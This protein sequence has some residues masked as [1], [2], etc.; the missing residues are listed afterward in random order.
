[1]GDT[2]LQPIAVAIT[3]FCPCLAFVFVVLRTYSRYFLTETLDWDDTLIGIPMVLSIGLAYVTTEVELRDPAHVQPDLALV[4]NAALFLFLRVGG[5]KPTLRKF[6]WALL[7]INNAMMVAIFVADMLQCIP[8]RKTFYPTIPGQC[9]SIGD[10]FIATAALTILTDIL[11]L[12]IPVWLVAGLQ[13]K[14]SKKVAVTFLLSLGLV[15]TAVGAFRMWYLID[16]YYGAPN[17]DATYG[18]A[19]TASSIEVNLAIIAACGPALKPLLHYWFPRLFGNT[20]NASSMGPSGSYGLRYGKSMATTKR[21]T[22]H[23]VRNGSTPR[24]DSFEL[25]SFPRKMYSCKERGDTLNDDDSAKDI[26][27]SNRQGIMR[28]TDIDVSYTSI[29][30]RPESWP[31]TVQDETDFGGYPRRMTGRVTPE[32]MV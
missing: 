25:R 26:A 13:L 28:K 27:L 18:V 4:K 11:V 16:S 29:D 6:I 12:I 30:S 24:H 10:F 31:V 14:L 20:K 3:I 22:I 8:I 15:V 2:G 17:P 5:S 32:R 19:G 7:I 1:M 23:T 9:I 21:S